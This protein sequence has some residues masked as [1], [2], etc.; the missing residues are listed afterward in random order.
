[1]TTAR[2]LRWIGVAGVV[3]LSG[4]AFLGLNRFTSHFDE[5]IVLL[6]PPV[7]GAMLWIGWP[8]VRQVRWWKLAVY[9]GVMGLAVIG[10]TAFAAYAARGRILWS[11]VGWAWHFCVGWRLAWALWAKAVGRLGEVRRRWGRRQ[12]RASGGLLRMAGL[13]RRCLAA[14]AMLVSPLRV[15]LVALIFVPLL[16]GSMIHRIKIGNPLDLADYASWPIEAVSFRTVDGLM[17]SG[18]FLPDRDA[19]ST[20]VICHGA[21]A[22]KGNFIDF[23]SLFY[24][25]GHNALIFDFRGHGDSD[26]HTST[27]GLFEEADVWAAVDWL[28]ENRPEQARHVYGLGSSMGAMA[29]VRAAAVDPRIEAIILD[30]AYLSAPRLAE[31]HLSRLPVIGPAMARL[32]LASLS[33]HA[34]ASFWKLDASEDIA[35]LAPRPLLLIH[36]ADDVLIPPEILDEL[37]D[38]AR[39]PKEKWLGP[40]PHSNIMTTAFGGYQERVL[41]FLKR[42]GA[43][44]P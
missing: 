4:A 27:F 22:N 1:M 30:S 5:T 16:A 3:V 43:T 31:Q 34:G 9:G 2:S 21:G 40:G 36:G 19:D 35:R 24:A 20:V 12:R 44:P 28:K 14:L 37:F 6:M 42:A 11:E 41:A 32:M 25:A 10:A 38:A 29:L 17:L 18:W 23:L 33:L 8:E 39:E 26:G 7:L 13:Q 15:T